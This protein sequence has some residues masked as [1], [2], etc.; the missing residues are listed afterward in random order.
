MEKIDPKAIIFFFLETTSAEM[1]RVWPNYWFHPIALNR[2]QCFIFKI[3]DAQL[4][5][6]YANVLCLAMLLCIDPPHEHVLDKPIMK[7]QQEVS[8]KIAI[9]EII[10]PS[11]CSRPLQSFQ[12]R[13]SQKKSSQLHITNIFLKTIELQELQMTLMKPKYY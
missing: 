8:F 4:A 3:F 7:N 1:N 12:N 9:I 11:L 6:E 10:S 13:R 2:I 5:V